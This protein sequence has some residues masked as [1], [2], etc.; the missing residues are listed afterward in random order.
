MLSNLSCLPP[1]DKTFSFA[2]GLATS[3]TG[4]GD[5]EG[6]GRDNGG[7]GEADGRTEGAKLFFCSCCSRYCSFNIKSVPLTTVDTSFNISTA[8]W[9]SSIP[10]F[11]NFFKFNTLDMSFIVHLPPFCFRKSMKLCFHRSSDCVIRPCSTSGN[12]TL[13]RPTIVAKEG[14]GAVE[15]LAFV[16]NACAGA[17]VVDA[18]VFCFFVGRSSRQ[19][20]CSSKSEPASEPESSGRT[21]DSNCS[22]TFSS[23]LSNCL[24]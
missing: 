10:S 17:S 7:E 23:R 18:R 22:S 9:Y 21:C 6:S 19:S 2:A 3:A 14:A 11:F 8:F 24:P 5:G 20:S 4:G 12:I 15:E 13:V 16:T 1:C